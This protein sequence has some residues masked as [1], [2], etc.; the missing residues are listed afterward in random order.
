MKNLFTLFVL[1]AI[2]LSTVAQEVDLSKANNS[3]TWFKLGVN[4]GLPVADL[5]NFSSYTV[6]PELTVQYLHTKAFGLGLKAGYTFYKGKGTTSDFSTIPL[7]VL[8]RFYPENTGFYAGI[9]LGYAFIN[10]FPGTSG[11]FMTRPHLGWHTYYW[12]F[13]GYYNHIVTED[14]VPD[15]KTIGLGISYNLRAKE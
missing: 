7:A 9:D 3:N 10:D 5:S 8:F 12:N 2:A 6:G 14:L 11:G 15:L 1:L 13:F 4:A